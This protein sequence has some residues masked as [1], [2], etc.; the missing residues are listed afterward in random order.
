MEL[1][2]PFEDCG[3]A[4]V[5]IRKA[6]EADAVAIVEILHNLGWFAHLKPEMHEQTVQQIKQQIALYEQNSSHSIYVAEPV[7]NSSLNHALGY[8]T[9]HWLPY[10]F[11]LSSEGFISELFVHSYHRGQGIGKALLDAVISEAADRG[12]SRL[13][14]VNSKNRESYQRQFYIKQGWLERE[15]IA[16][17]I[18]PLMHNPSI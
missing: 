16:N 6:N 5:T 7:K 1:R 11:L 18:Y 4:N 13:M 10:L 14:L 12:C 2:E 9:V 15:Y 3:M 17:F 8:V